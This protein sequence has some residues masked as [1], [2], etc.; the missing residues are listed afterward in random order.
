MMKRLFSSLKMYYKPSVVEA[1]Y[2]TGYYERLAQHHL[3]G[4]PKCLV[5]G[6]HRVSHDVPSLRAH[7]MWRDPMEIGVPVSTFRAQMEFLRRHMTPVPM[8]DV[9]YF[10]TGE[11]E[12]PSRAVAVTF[13]DGYRDNYECAY[14]I[15]C[16]YGIPA[17]IFVTTGMI[18][19]GCRLWW[20]QLFDML[21]YTRRRFVDLSLVEG[22]NKDL[23]SQPCILPLSTY[24]D[25]HEAADKLVP[26]LKALSPSRI[27]TAIEFL[28]EALD[29]PGQNSSDDCMLSWDQISN[30]DQNLIEIG[31]HTVT[32]PSLPCLAVEDAEAEIRQSQKAIEDRLGTQVRGFA[33]PYGHMNED[34]EKIIQKMGFE[35]ACSSLYGAIDKSSN[36]FTLPRLGLSESGEASLARRMTLALQYAGV[37]WP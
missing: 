26:M 29:V 25:R 34:M 28:R 1:L 24:S 27:I 37:P 10:L 36:P 33:Y 21:R 35:Y 23:T 32:H 17:T 8:S 6:Y 14:P 3:Y 19:T 31:A 5:V 30:M 13:D 7:E 15:L 2:R 11:K 22:L 9:P 12:M 4:G 16:E 20:D 18:E